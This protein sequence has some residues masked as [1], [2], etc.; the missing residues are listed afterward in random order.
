MFRLC[1]LSLTHSHTFYKN[2][3]FEI[4][5]EWSY[6]STTF[7]MD[8]VITNNVLTTRRNLLVE[9]GDACG[10]ILFSTYTISLFCCRCSHK[11]FLIKK[12]CLGDPIYRLSMMSTRVNNSFIET[13]DMKGSDR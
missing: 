2:L 7:L 13:M 5:I 1:A 8:M 11:V 4:V 3:I 12:M 9:K 6:A 10:P